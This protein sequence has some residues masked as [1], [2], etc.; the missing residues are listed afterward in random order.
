MHWT[1]VSTLL[2]LISSAHGDLH[3]WRTNQQPQYAEAETQPL[4][5]RF[6]LH[7]SEAELKSHSELRDHFDLYLDIYISLMN[8]VEKLG[9][10][11]QN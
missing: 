11:K 3:H 1:A 9:I 6:V 10:T 7:I 4:G 8:T 5:H 2:G